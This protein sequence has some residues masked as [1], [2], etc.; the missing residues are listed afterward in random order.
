MHIQNIYVSENNA[1]VL[2]VRKFSCTNYK[3]NLI[4]ANKLVS[5]PFSFHLQL[6]RNH[7]SHPFSLSSSVYKMFI[8]KKYSYVGKAKETCYLWFWPQESQQILDEVTRVRSWF[9]FKNAV[10]DARAES[11]PFPAPTKHIHW[12]C[13]CV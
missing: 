5:S 9:L 6:L 4:V 10:F 12:V 1:C 8:Y 3:N 7:K 2:S 13:G 11:F